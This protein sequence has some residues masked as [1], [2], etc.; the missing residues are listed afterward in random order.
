FLQY[1]FEEDDVVFLKS[2]G[3]NCVR[4]PFN[5]RHFEDDARPGVYKESGFKHLDRVVDLCA[6]HGVYTILDLHAT[7]G[8]Q[9]P[10]WHSDNAHHRP[11][12][13][14]Y[15]EFQDRTVN[16]WRHLASH[17]KGNPWV[18]GYN[19][20][21][22]PA[23][24]DA[25][26]LLSLYDRLEKAIR[27]IDPDHI[28]FWDGN[29]FASDFSAFTSVYPNSVYACHDYSKL[30]FPQDTQYEGTDQQKQALVQSYERKVTFQKKR[31]VPIWNGE[32]GPVYDADESVN[33]K[34]YALV[35]QQIAIYSHEGISW[36]IWTY[37]DVNYQGLIYLNPDSP[38]MKL[39]SP[40]I[41]RKQRVAA[42]R[43]GSDERPLQYLFKPLEEWFAQEVTPK[44]QKKYP[45][46]WT[47]ND[48][49]KCQVR[50]T[51]LSEY[52]IPDYADLFQ[53]ASMEE[54]EALAAS[55]KFSQCKRR[56][57]LNEI[58]ANAR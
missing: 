37:K 21:N 43:W 15:V 58:L 57:R 2:L 31:Q 41:E 14:D 1:F 19:P 20:I 28:L 39:V 38:Y 47:I 42:D 25:S 8:G 54:L 45:S 33:E 48:W 5:Y 9:N 17:Y 35:A 26:K 52:L 10:G 44:Y 53:N 22:E 49:I 55:F 29:T 46:T 27:E 51:L 7:V 13:F 6:R 56:D 24:E 34:R 16:L 23:V 12:L 30:G 3:M 4:L 36:S 40:F 50:N 32:F 11:I 18:A